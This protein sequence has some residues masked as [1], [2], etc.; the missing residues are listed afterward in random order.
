LRRIVARA[1]TVAILAAVAV[2]G[3]ASAAQAHTEVEIDNPRAGAVN[4]RM[5][6][7]AEAE[8]DSA[9]IAS[10]R[11]VLP[12]GITA[13]QITVVTAP[14]GWTLKATPDGYTI[15]GKALPTGTDARTVSRIAQLP[16]SATVLVFKTLVTYADGDV[17]R[18]IE[19]PTATAPTPDNPAP[20]VSLRPAVATAAPAPSAT[21]SPATSGPPAAATPTPGQTAQGDPSS[22]IG[23]VVGAAL[24][25]AAAAV[26]VA[27]VARRRAGTSGGS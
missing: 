12:A 5:T 25:V 18:W 13:S 23:W 26:V 16:P 9:G 4:V 8:S 17:D 10:L 22:P 7:T 11:V 3:A 15:G 19:V 14:A 27:V 6:M 24:V 2:V 21:T 20:V 1:G